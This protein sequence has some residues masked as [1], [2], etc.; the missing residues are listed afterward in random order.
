[1]LQNWMTFA[2]LLNRVG[3]NLQ[4]ACNRLFVICN[5]LLVCVC[6]YCKK[7]CVNKLVSFSDILCRGGNVR[8]AF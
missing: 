7:K 2:L 8:V 5:T 1:M 4:V 3:L 6:D